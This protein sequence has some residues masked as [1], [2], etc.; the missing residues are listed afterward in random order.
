[1]LSLRD[2]LNSLTAS[3]WAL[4]LAL[5]VVF[6]RRVD[7]GRG[8]AA[9]RPYELATASGGGSWYLSRREEPEGQTAAATIGS[10]PWKSIKDT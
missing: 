9:R 10:R 3:R 1:M 7:V 2:Q 5:V 6:D 8:Y 4:I